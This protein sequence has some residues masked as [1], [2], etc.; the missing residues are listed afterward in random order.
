MDFFDVRIS[1]IIKENIL[2]Y[3][4]RQEKGQEIT[5]TITR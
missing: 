4:D 3:P 2:R 5:S 1:L